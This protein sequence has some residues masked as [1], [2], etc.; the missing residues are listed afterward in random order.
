MSA[1]VFQDK[2]PD[3]ELFVKV[4]QSVVFGILIKGRDRRSRIPSVRHQYVL[5]RSGNPI[6]EMR[7]QRQADPGSV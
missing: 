4:R 6:G 2:D 1:E 7:F 3:I 5:E